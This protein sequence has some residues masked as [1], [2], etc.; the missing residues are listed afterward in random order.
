MGEYNVVV[1]RGKRGKWVKSV[2][3]YFIHVYLKV[4]SELVKGTVSRE[5]F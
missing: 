5:F 4:I 3:K 2:G 1:L